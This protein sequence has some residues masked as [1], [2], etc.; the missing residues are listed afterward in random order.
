MPKLAEEIRQTRPFQVLEEEA[1]LNI[2]RTADYLAQRAGELLKTFDLSEPQYNILRILRGAGKDGLPCGAIGERMVSH[3]PDVTR[4]L[5]RME[6]RG[7]I[8]RSRP[9]EDR[10]MVVA[11]IT[12][13]GL[14]LVN[15]MDRPV[16]E[17]NR[18]LL[19]HLGEKKLRKLIELMELV[20]EAA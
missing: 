16:I 7:L 3:N 15:T 11:R 13:R 14:D 4:L 2:F 20:R 8:R 19:G 1:A 18:K 17:F 5:N 6:E 9:P 10:R 12:E